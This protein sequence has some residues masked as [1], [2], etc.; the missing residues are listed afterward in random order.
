MTAQEY[1]TLSQSL[2]PYDI[3]ME[4]VTFSIHLTEKGTL[5]TKLL[6]HTISVEMKLMI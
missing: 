1:Q 5:F 2:T 6:K 4:K 3:L